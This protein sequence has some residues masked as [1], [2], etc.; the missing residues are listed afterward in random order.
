M[1]KSSKSIEAAIAGLESLRSAPDAPAAI[2]KALDDSSN[3]IVAKAA[4]LARDLKLESLAPRMSA[5][6]ARTRRSP[7]RSPAVAAGERGATA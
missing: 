6:F 7:S 5:A 2:E 3:L 4:Q 1:A